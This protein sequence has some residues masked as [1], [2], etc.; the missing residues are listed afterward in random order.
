M[1]QKEKKSGLVILG[2]LVF[3]GI[4][5]VLIPA[6]RSDGII[7]LSAK[8]TQEPNQRS[9]PS[10][11]TPANQSNPKRAIPQPVNPSVSAVT[12]AAVKMGVL[13]CVSR[14]NQVATALT[15]NAQSGVYI[16]PVQTPPD[17]HIFSTS[18]ELVRPDSST[19]YATAS[20]FPNQD[21]VY[22]TVEYVNK[23]CEEVE[24]TIFKNLKRVSM[25]KKNVI[26]LDGGAVK[27]FLMP[28]GSG[29]IVIKKEV[30]Q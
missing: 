7:M 17:Q 14:I 28:A 12:Q 16:F 29:C 4:S 26:L 2:I 30:V 25:L 1:T 9:V 20:F 8:A 22:D 21:A 24:K 10:P 5:I 27:V 15:A 23:S 19:I 11:N 3:S 13:S 18:F 6:V